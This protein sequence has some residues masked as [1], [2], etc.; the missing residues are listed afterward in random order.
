ME[1]LVTHRFPLS[2]VNDAFETLLAGKD[3]DGAFVMK[4]MVG[5]Y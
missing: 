3:K 5:D 2:A 4:L 1:K